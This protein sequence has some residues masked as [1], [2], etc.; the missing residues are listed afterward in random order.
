LLQETR[1]LIASLRQV[2]GK[3]MPGARSRVWLDDFTAKAEIGAAAVLLRECVKPQALPA[4]C[5]S[6]RASTSHLT[7]QNADGGTPSAFAFL[8]PCS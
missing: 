6:I 3:A 5:R 8:G 2:G 1:T 4:A 7:D